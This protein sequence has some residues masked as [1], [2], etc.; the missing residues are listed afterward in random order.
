M[1]LWVGLQSQRIVRTP[2][3]PTQPKRARM[4]TGVRASGRRAE[5]VRSAARFTLLGESGRLQD[6]AAAIVNASR[7][8][9]SKARP[10]STNHAVKPSGVPDAKPRAAAR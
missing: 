3:P 2:R 1:T 6:D 4:V 9:A 7:A 10:L 8:P 5:F